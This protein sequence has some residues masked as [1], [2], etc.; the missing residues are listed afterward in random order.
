MQLEM[1]SGKF[2]K[3][4]KILMDY[5]IQKI[6]FKKKVFKIQ[7]GILI[8][9]IFIFSLLGF[10]L[11]KYALDEKVLKQEYGINYYCYKCGYISGKSC[12]CSYMPK[13]ASEDR[14]QYFI[15]LGERNAQNCNKNTI[16]DDIDFILDS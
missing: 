16:I 5:T 7:V 8:G 13:T 1:L 2:N 9:L 12:M 15:D 6:N 10:Y 14:E 4:E 11:F 3:D